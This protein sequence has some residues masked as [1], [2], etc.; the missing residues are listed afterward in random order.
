MFFLS[1]RALRTLTNYVHVVTLFPI[2]LT[3]KL[4]KIFTSGFHVQIMHALK[5]KNTKGHLPIIFESIFN[6]FFKR[7]YLFASCEH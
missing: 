7:L 4:I 1:M 6:Y 3:P 2:N 5:I